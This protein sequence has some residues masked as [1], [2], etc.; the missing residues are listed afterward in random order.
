VY[1]SALISA[2]G[3]ADHPSIRCRTA[4]D[5]ASAASFHP[6]NALTN[7]G[8]RRVGFDNHCTDAGVAITT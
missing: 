7:V 4:L 3:V 8:F 2:S 6:V 5:A 1:G